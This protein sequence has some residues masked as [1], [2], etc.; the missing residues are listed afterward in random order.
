MWVENGK[1][2][3][4]TWT[5]SS[6]L[7][8]IRECSRSHPE[9][10]STKRRRVSLCTAQPDYSN[11]F[12]GWLGEERQPSRQKGNLSRSK[13]QAAMECNGE[14]ELSLQR[15]ILLRNRRENIKKGPNY[16]FLKEAHANCNQVCNATHRSKSVRGCVIRAV[17]SA[18]SGGPNQP[19]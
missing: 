8:Q 2:A 16:F 7:D 3:A 15:P 4:S 18:T 5:Q 11:R 17:A 1:N 9:W 13:K 14:I 19:T 6:R 12:P 10:Q